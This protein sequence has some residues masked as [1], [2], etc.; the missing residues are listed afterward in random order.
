MAGDFGFLTLS[1]CGDWPASLVSI[2]PAGS[3]RPET[4]VRWHRAGFRCYFLAG[5]AAHLMPPFAGQGMPQGLAPS[6]LPAAAADPMTRLQ[7]G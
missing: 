2:H 3:I 6:D 7:F 5:D 1:Q 4:L